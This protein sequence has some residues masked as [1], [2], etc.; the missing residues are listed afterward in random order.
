MAGATVATA[1][2]A[3][4]FRGRG[5]AQRTVD[6]MMALIGAWMVIASR[7][8]DG[9]TVK[10]LCFGG[11]AALWGLAVLGLIAHE[12]RSERALRTV[13]ELPSNGARQ[14]T[15]RDQRQMAVR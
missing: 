9:T 11:A 8:F 13:V 5:P 2:I 7:A 12:L 15:L 3:F 4:C 14:A 10:W 6:V 1:L